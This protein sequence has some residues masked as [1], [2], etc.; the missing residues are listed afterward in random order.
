MISF[1]CGL[2]FCRCGVSEGGRG[3]AR[4]PHYAPSLQTALHVHPKRRSSQFSI[5]FAY[6]SLLELTF[7]CTLMERHV[8]PEVGHQDTVKK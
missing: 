3:P 1:F 4:M 6:P 2:S 5:Q 7:C 8:L